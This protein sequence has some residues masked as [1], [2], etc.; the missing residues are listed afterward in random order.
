M[1]N[2]PT[3]TPTRDTIHDRFVRAIFTRLDLARQLLSITLPQEIVK[4]VDLRSLRLASGTFVGIRRTTRQVDLLYEL[5]ARDDR[6]RFVIPVLVEHK[7]SLKST[8]ALFTQLL[9]YL[10]EIYDRDNCAIVVPVVLYHGRRR[11]T[12]PQRFSETLG[13]AA[14]MLRPYFPDF[15]YLLYDTNQHNP[16]DLPT[17]LT[18]RIVLSTLHDVWLTKTTTDLQR[19][20]HKLLALG[21]TAIDL[22]SECLDYIAEY[23]DLSL[24]A[25]QETDKDNTGGAVVRKLQDEW[26]EQGIEQ[27][28]Q[29]GLAESQRLQDEWLEQGIEQ[30]RQQGIKL[31]IE[32]DRQEV[33]RRMLSEGLDISVIAKISGLSKRDISTLQP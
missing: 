27:G 1:S 26:L 20:Y 3:K 31:G 30:G 9:R 10:A 17:P 6:T 13:Y 18:V 33:A 19:I 24:A 8:R 11:W 2:Q 7:S 4:H 21:R 32:R 5:P 22:I 14:D 12:A 28:R 23:A 16:Q 29:Q 25:L 15:S